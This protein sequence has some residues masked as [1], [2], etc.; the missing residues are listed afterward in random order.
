MIFW[1]LVITAIYAMTFKNAIK[2][3]VNELIGAY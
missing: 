2:M 3:A 1:I